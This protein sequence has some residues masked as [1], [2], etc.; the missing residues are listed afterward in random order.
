MSQSGFCEVAAGEHSISPHVSEFHEE[1]NGIK[2]EGEGEGLSLAKH[3][4]LH[5]KKRRK[6]VKPGSVNHMNGMKWDMAE[7]SKREVKSTQ[8]FG[9]RNSTVTD[10]D[11]AMP[12]SDK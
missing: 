3:S 11:L 7:Q 12:P 10:N 2:H 8:Q 9:G 4:R 5:K 1:S 6:K